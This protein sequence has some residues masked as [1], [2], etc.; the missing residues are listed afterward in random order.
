MSIMSSAGGA[1]AAPP[2]AGDGREAESANPLRLNDGLLLT[3]THRMTSGRGSHVEGA[4]KPP[5]ALTRLFTPGSINRAMPVPQRTA[6][7]RRSS[8]KYSWTHITASRK[9]YAGF[10][11]HY[12]DESA[13]EARLVQQ[14]VKKVL[15]EN[16]KQTFFLVICLLV[17]RLLS[18]D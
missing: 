4:P 18:C 13:S 8:T 7:R 15:N 1:G 9:K 11:S 3:D 12:K 10:L 14:T 2:S 5:P 17:S 6:S 16:D